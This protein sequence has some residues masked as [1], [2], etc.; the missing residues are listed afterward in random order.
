MQ[1]VAHAAQLDDAAIDDLDDVE[2]LIEA[3]YSQE[4]LG[5]ILYFVILL[6]FC[7]AVDCKC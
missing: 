4:V 2:Q 1:F 5:W 6:Y 7:I 3:K